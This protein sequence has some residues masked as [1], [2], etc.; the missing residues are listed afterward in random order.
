MFVGAVTDLL[1]VALTAGMF[2]YGYF[3]AAIL[4]GLLG[5]LIRSVIN[6]TH[7]K[8]V[9]FLFISTIII[10]LVMA[11]SIM[12]INLVDLG[13]TGTFSGTVLGLNIELTK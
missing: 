9:E 4:Y 3:I 12:Y 6:I 11:L 2:H 13:V 8:Q 5:G 10:L 7:G 1:S